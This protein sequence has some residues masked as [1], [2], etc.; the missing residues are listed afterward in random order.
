MKRLLKPFKTNKAEGYIDTV[1]CV[2]AAMMVIV[3]ALN[4]F[5]FL[6]FKQDIDHFAKELIDTATTYGRTNEQVTDRYKELC[7]ELGISPTVSFSGTTYYNATAKKVQLGETIR[8]TLTY[9][10]YV[11]GL[12]VLKIPVTLRASFSGLSQKYWK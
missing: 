7:A 12:G 3:L 2:I 10:T 6:T 1:V 5:S 4:I 11:R 9:K 8:V